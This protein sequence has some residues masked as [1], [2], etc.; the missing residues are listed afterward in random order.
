LFEDRVILPFN[1]EIDSYVNKILSQKTKL[2]GFS[3]NAGNLFFSIELARRIKNKDQSRIIIFG[4]PHSRWFEFEIS[5]LD[6]YPDWYRG[7]YPGLVDI[8]VIGEGEG[9]LL[10]I[11]NRFKD[12]KELDNI[13]GT[14]LY[15]NKYLNF[16]GDNF[17]PDLNTLPLADFSWANLEEYTE[18]KL[19]IL[20]SRGCIRRCSFC[21]D[22]FVSAKYRCRSAENVFQE[23]KTRIQNH[24]INNFEFL[25]LIL[26]G[27]LA[28]LE[29]LCD[30]IIGENIN[31]TWSGQGAIRND[32]S[33]VLLNK[34]K[35]AGCTSLTYGTESFTDRVLK[36]MRKPYTYKD[37]KAVLKNTANSGIPAAVNIV[38][39]FPG[40][41]EEDFR[42]SIKRLKQCCGYINK[43]SSLSPCLI[44]LGSSLQLHL[45]EYGI[46]YPPQ[47]GYF[48]WYTNY[49]NN[50]ELR[51]RRAKE[52]LSVALQFK[53]QVGVINLYDEECGAK[54]NGEQALLPQNK[55]P[56][57][58][59]V[60]WKERNAL[61]WLLL[62]FIL[63]VGFLYLTYFWLVMLL[64]NQLILGGRR[65]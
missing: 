4:G 16:K 61:K 18:R 17:T 62:T 51:K 50:Y 26:N 23:I 54:I 40:E 15:K 37:I 24:K 13:P 42:K 2:I 48:K 41:S 64:R 29:E 60:F 8:F 35:K 32:M 65:K 53:L 45:E 58:H 59:L 44:T 10:E 39:G 36:L 20:L 11:L 5:N 27:N 21:N 25:D 19:P 3:V 12:K 31:L 6:Q 46:I 14:I 34:M 47:D 1:D 33:F 57:F 28:E 56:V 30:L 22:T 9:T 52:F 43:I 7:F 49:G 55:L 63:S 38:T